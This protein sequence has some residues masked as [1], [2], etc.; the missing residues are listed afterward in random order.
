MF[1]SD[2]IERIY[3]KRQQVFKV[4]R[5]VTKYDHAQLVNIIRM[6]FRKYFACFNQVVNAFSFL[7]VILTEPNRINCLSCGSMHRSLASS[8]SAGLNRLV[9]IGLGMLKIFLPVNKLLFP[10]SLPANGC[11]SQ[12]P[13]NGLCI[14]FVFAIGAVRKVFLASTS[15]D[16]RTIV[17]TFL[18]IGAFTCVVANASAWPHVMHSPHN[19]F[20]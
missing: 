20:A 6:F 8:L 12:M 19:R 14:S 5:L 4:A 16:E 18:I 7:S 17:A 15:V 1:I 11:K 10:C 9:L 2:I 3:F 13:W